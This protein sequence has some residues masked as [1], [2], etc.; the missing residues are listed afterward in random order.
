MLLQSRYELRDDFN[1]AQE[2][3]SSLEVLRTSDNLVFLASDF[4]NVYEEHPNGE[5][6]Q[7]AGAILP[8]VSESMSQILN[9]YNIISLVDLIHH[10]LEE[11]FTENAGPLKDFSV[12][13]NMNAGSL[14]QLLPPLNRLPGPNDQEN[15]IRLGRS[16][17]TF[18]PLPEGLCWHVLRS[19]SRA[20]LWLHYGLK[21]T[22]EN[23]DHYETLD[24]DW[25]P[26]LIRDVS[27]SR[28]WFQHPIRDETYGTCKLGGFVLAKV[29]NSIDGSEP[30]TTRPTNA[31]WEKELFWAP[32][33]VS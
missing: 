25:Q 26:I 5:R 24:Q 16:A 30:I 20:L 3:G 10:S 1:D 12:W 17:P 28:I 11:P 8:S 14:D 22:H 33:S 13:E 15:W 27:P 23:N 29:V 4:S 2:S 21:K 18:Q 7:L 31:G 6:T 19:V 32:V 9:H